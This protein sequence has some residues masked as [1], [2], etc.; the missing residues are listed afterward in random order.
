MFPALLGFPALFLAILLTIL[1]I[2]K[3]WFLLPILSAILTLPMSYYLHGSSDLRW[4]IW[5]VPLGLLGSAYAIR[6]G[7]RRLAWVMLLPLVLV[8]MLIIPVAMWVQFGQ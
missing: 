1:G 3:R 7:K 6:Q 8:V 5:L 2:W 4:V